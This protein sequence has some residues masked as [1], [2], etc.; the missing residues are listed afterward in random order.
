MKNIMF[1]FALAILI[2]PFTQ[3]QQL[4]GAV[5]NESKGATQSAAGEMGIYPAAQVKWTDGPGIAARWSKACGAG[6]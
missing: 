5:N 4:A 2:A 6:G 3:A 1:A